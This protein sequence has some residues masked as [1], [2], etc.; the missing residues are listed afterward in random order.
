MSDFNPRSPRGE[1]LFSKVSNSKIKRFQ[2]TL[3]SRGAT[4]GHHVLGVV[5]LISTHAPL[6]GSDHGD[7]GLASERVKIS[8]HAPLAGSD[9]L[10]RRKGRLFPISTHAPLAGSDADRA[11][12]ARGDPDFNPRSPRGERLE[13]WVHRADPRTFQPTLPSRGATGRP[14][15][16]VYFIQISTHAPL[17][18]SDRRS[19][20]GAAAH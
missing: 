6:A 18:G 9:D 19:W 20:A 5:L 13:S 1:R 10:H 17:A 8:T 14:R 2:P 12:E 3:P 15:E 7:R 4:L 16:F 11:R